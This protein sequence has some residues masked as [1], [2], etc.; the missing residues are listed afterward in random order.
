M[1]REIKYMKIEPN[2]RLNRQK[3]DVYYYENI[4]QM[5]NPLSK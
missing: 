5:D 1:T 4:Q 3:S 2:Q